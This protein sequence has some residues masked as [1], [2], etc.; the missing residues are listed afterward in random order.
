MAQHGNVFRVTIL[1]VVLNNR[2]GDSG[3]VTM[4][5]ARSIL[6]TAEPT[7]EESGSRSRQLPDMDE[8]V[9]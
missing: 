5:E 9:R 2:M 6:T 7:V 3:Q 4:S 1:D 8:S